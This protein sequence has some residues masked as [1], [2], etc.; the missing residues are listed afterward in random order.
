MQV[1]QETSKVVWY[2]HFFKNFP[3]FVVIHTVKVLRLV[4]EAEV[5]IFLEFPGFLY[6]V[7][8]VSNLILGS[9]AFSKFSLHIWKI[10]IHIPLKPILKDMG[11]NLTSMWSECIGSLNILWHCASLG[12]EWKNDLFQSCGHCWVF[13]I[14]WH[15]E[16]ST[17]TTPSF[18]IWN[19]SAGIPTPPL[20][21]LV[22]MLPKTHLTSHSWMSGCR[23]VTTPSWLSQ[24]LRTF[25][26]CSSAYFCHLFLLFCFR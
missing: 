12:F 14:C 11:H 16:C 8:N 20:A 5:D 21:L 15:I 19:S 7:M 24:S 3:Q 25:L 10:S 6:D 17:L 18:R 9:S 23:W 2:S 4:S 1:A 26:Y 13:Q 22:G